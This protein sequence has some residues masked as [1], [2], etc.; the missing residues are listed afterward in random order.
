MTYY[1]L[2]LGSYIETKEDYINLDK[3]KWN[4][5][6]DVVHDLN[7][8]PYPFD[9]NTF[10]EI[11]ARFI[12][13]HLNPLKL[14]DVINELYRITKPGGKWFVIVPYEEVWM[15]AIDHYRGFNFQFFKLL[16]SRKSSNEIFTKSKLELLKL[17]HTPTLAGKF[18][19]N[20]RLR[21]YISYFIKGLIYS[22]D[23]E[24]KV[25]KEQ[26]KGGIKNGNNKS[27]NK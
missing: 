15:G 7:E 3:F 14:K 17:N 21:K 26:R 12:F 4:N 27:N 2:N 25:I 22:I 9:D 24:M 20:N 11:Y 23:V 5:K 10:S 8:F 16:C 6:I 19:P 18:I 13:E 1:K